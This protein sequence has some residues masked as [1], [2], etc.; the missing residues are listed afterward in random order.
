MTIKHLVLCGGGPAGFITYGAIRELAKRDFWSLESIASIYGTSIGS[1]IGVIISLGYDWKWVDDYLMKRPWDK[2]ADLTPL[3]FLEAFQKKGIVD[4]TV[5]YE[6]LAPLF[7][8]KDISA[9]VTLEQL[10]EYNQIDIHI[11]ATEMNGERLK[12][13]D[14]SHTTHPDLPVS[15]AIAMSTAYPFIFAPICY[16]GGC[17]IDGGVV[18]NFPLEDCFQQQQCDK[19]EVL[20]FK[21][22]WKESTQRIS[23]HSTMLDFLV[24]LFKRMKH[25][26]DS[27]PE[28]RNIEHIVKFVIDDMNGFGAW[29]DALEGEETRRSLI[30]RGVIQADTFIEYLMPPSE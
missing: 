3:S 28:Q 4:H 20:A 14:L 25:E 19:S 8:A 11:Y 27:E 26:V 16:E 9:D 7:T 1:F 30:Q 18:N 21:N 22:I 12:K 13:V 24:V 29:T 5:I 6:S 17:Y 15:L 10:Y 23:E 2:V